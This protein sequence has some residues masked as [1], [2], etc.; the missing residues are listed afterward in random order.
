MATEE[1][2]S[3]QTI[4]VLAAL[5]LPL[6]YAFRRHGRARKLTLLAYLP[7]VLFVGRAV[8]L[9]PSPAVPLE[10]RV[11]RSLIE[12]LNDPMLLAWPAFVLVV[13]GLIG[14]VR[15]RRSTPGA[16]MGAVPGGYHGYLQSD[17]WRQ[18]RRDAIQRADGRCQVCNGS[19]PLEVHHRTYERL[20]HESPGDL[21][22]LC[23]ACHA[24]FHEGGR[25]PV[26]R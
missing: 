9:S 23:R 3:T 4:I 7:F 14:F 10:W 15:R 5:V 11:R 21:T 19:G 1:P 12:L 16:P 24:R 22:V 20:G 18:R 17:A 8:Y 2:T 13:Y 6:V 25:M 26:R